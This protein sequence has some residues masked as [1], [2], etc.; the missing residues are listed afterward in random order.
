[1]TE[2]N[3]TD[4]YKND[5]ALPGADFSTN[6]AGNI[7][8]LTN[9]L[10]EDELLHEVPPK[11]GEVQSAMS[12]LP[13]EYG[14]LGATSVEIKH[15]GGDGSDGPLMI[16]SGTTTI[17][18]GGA[19]V[20]IKNYSSISILETGSLAFSNPHAGGTLIILRSKGDVVLTSS[21]APMIDA[22]G[23][24]ATGGGASANGTNAT[25][26]LDTLA[27]YGSTGSSPTGG[28]A[29]VAYS[30][31]PLYTDTAAKLA[32]LNFRLLT[33]G[34][35]GG[36]GALT[37][38]GTG[39]PGSGG[40]GGAALIIECAGFLNFTT[41]G[42]ISVAGNAGSAGGAGS[43]AAGGGGGGGASIISNLGTAGGTSTGAA[44]NLGGGGGGGG[45]GG[46]CLILYNLLVSSSGTITVA[47]GAGGTG[48]DV[49]NSN[50]GGT[51]ATGYSLVVKNTMF[52]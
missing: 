16:S 36:G 18:L 11:G 24:G 27:H 46:M 14:K 28:I 20:V 44:G 12:F 50:V 48:G 22:S 31:L 41:P 37:S 9:D 7:K 15:F 32:A 25:S 52:A 33:P 13:D 35:G 38:A 39:S 19:S 21:A 47:G 42:G 29:G 3:I 49:N 4:E 8:V 17:N 51:G 1:M 2:K 45:A 10:K 43:G 23:L 5:E 30:H 26:I 34:S 40:R 6:E